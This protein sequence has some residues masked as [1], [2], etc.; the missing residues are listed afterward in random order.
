MQTIRGIQV[1]EIISRRYFIRELDDY[2]KIT[3]LD[4]IILNEIANDGYAYLG[5]DHSTNIRFR[6]KYDTEQKEFLYEII[7]FKD[8]EGEI[9][10]EQIFVG[11]RY[12][13]QEKATLDNNSNVN[14][15][16]H[17]LFNPCIIEPKYQWRMNELMIRKFTD[18]PFIDDATEKRIALSLSFKKL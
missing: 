11:N 9:H 5:L 14:S 15:S 1:K 13:Y 8:E 18:M 3:Y 12:S 7:K 6:K 2:N 17:D 10:T 16:N 4:G